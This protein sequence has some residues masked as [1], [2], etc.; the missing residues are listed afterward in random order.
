MYAVVTW[1]I[2][3]AAP[4][5][6]AIASDAIAAFGDRPICTLFQGAHIARVASTT[7]FVVVHEALARVADAHL[8]AFRYAAWAL[9]GASPMRTS[10]PFDRDLAREITGA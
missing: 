3:P 5:P 6:A 10:E 7:D 2:D 4:D 1:E 9:R 8:G